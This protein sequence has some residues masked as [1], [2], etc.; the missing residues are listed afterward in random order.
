MYYATG[1]IE[2]VSISFSYS[3]A[4]YLS[5]SVVLISILF[6]EK[7]AG[8]CVCVRALGADR[9]L[10]GFVCRSLNDIIILI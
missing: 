6:N 5:D 10:F 9:I 1:F 4:G 7:E 8:K 2:R 3:M